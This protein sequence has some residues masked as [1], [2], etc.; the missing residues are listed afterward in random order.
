MDRFTG[1]II[2]GV[3]ALVVAGVVAAVAVR[4][5]ET[6]PDMGTP[7]G[8]TLAYMQALQ[9]KDDE[10]AWSL[11]ATSTRARTN[12][13]Q[14]QQNVSGWGGGWGDRRDERARLILESEQVE[15]DRASVELVTQFPSSGGLLDFNGT[16]STRSTV[17]LV[18]EDGNWRITIPPYPYL[19]PR[20]AERP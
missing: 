13:F 14:F 7:G 2:A 12:R 6:P 11:L 15:G 18:R 4:G 9:R 3:L 1:V 16:Y 5:R 20:E 10:Q 17:R 19:L 8:V